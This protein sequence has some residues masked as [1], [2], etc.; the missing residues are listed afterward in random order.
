MAQ[1]K[2]PDGLWLRIQGEQR[3]RRATPRTGWILWPAIATVMLLASGD[4]VWQSVNA[5]SGRVSRPAIVR[6]KAPL[7]LV[8]AVSC[9]SCHLESGLY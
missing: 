9:N 6:V 8:S 5:A 1:V 2:A 4:L 7:Q 3:A